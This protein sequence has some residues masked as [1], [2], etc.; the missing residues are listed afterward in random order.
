M[1]NIDFSLIPDEMKAEIL[2][3]LERRAEYEKY[4]KLEEFYPY[5]F[6]QDFYRASKK[7]K[8]RFL[9]AANRVGKSFSEAAEVAWHLTG[10]YPEWWE[11]HRFEK[12]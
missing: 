5:K 1:S 2:E 8:S 3:L 12:P 9:C 7:Y 11:G 4:N 6:Q 10:I